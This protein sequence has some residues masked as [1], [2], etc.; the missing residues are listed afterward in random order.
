MD[1]DDFIPILCNYDYQTLFYWSK[2]EIN[3]QYS[4]IFPIQKHCANNERLILNI[5][6]Q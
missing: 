2:K 4:V 6:G 3:R 1:I 5:F